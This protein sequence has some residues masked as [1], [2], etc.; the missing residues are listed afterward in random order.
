MAYISRTRICLRIWDGDDLQFPFEPPPTLA[1]KG[2]LITGCKPWC[3]VWWPT[4]HTIILSFQLIGTIQSHQYFMLALIY[5]R[6]SN[7]ATQA[8][9]CSTVR[10]LHGWV[11]P[12]LRCDTRE[13]RYA[14]FQI[15]LA[16]LAIARSSIRGDFRTYFCLLIR[17]IQRSDWSRR[18]LT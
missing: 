14:I 8:L 2:V 11:I 6:S 17:W 4:Y 10:K 13:T 15:S 3:A 18:F 1:H 5:C 7:P 12:W 9:Q 16:I